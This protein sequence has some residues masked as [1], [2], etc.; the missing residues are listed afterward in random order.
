VNDEPFTAAIAIVAQVMRTGIAAHPE[1]DWTEVSPE[2]HVRKAH[3][4]LQLWCEGD[5][6]EDHVAHAATRL[7]MAL[8]LQVKQE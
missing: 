6:Q 1:N 5:E 3:E 7:L 2:H 8:T 4:H